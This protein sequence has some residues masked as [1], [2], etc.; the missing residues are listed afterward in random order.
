MGLR[1][2]LNNI[3]SSLLAQESSIF[4]HHVRYDICISV[5]LIARNP[6]ELTLSQTTTN[7]IGSRSH[8]FGTSINWFTT[9]IKFVIGYNPYNRV[10][11]QQHTVHTHLVPVGISPLDLLS[12]TKIGG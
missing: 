6:I 3:L 12:Y 10:L 1:T 7:S 5:A 11:T 8:P 2:T 9:L 4:I